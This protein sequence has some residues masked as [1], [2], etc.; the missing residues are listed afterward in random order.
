MQF[1]LVESS[2][3]VLQTTECALLSVFAHGALICL[4]AGL[5]AG[6]R[7]LPADEREARIFFLLPPDRVPVQPYQIETFQLGRLGVDFQDG[8]D[9]THASPGSRSRPK[10]II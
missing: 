5:T 10:S 6:G 7:Q 8:A 2:R 1:T 3:S 9:L 4:A